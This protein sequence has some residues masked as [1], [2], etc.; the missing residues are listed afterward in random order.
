MLMLF[1]HERHAVDTDCRQPWQ[2]MLQKSR[3]LRPSAWED[4]LSEQKHQDLRAALIW[5]LYSIYST[6]GTVAVTVTG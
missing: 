5:T 3:K 6:V 1:G 2:L 4:P